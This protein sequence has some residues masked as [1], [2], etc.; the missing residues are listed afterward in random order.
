MKCNLME[1]EWGQA[2]GK[3]VISKMLDTRE[4][5]AQQSS[6]ARNRHPK[7]SYSPISYHQMGGKGEGIAA[8]SLG[9]RLVR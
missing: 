6:T 3:I 7:K 9:K 2:E 8:N 1:I 4:R 5:L